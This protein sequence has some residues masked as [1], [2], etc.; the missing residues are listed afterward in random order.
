MS[1]FAYLKS[2]RFWGI[3]LLVV[4][5]LNVGSAFAYVLSDRY[6][7]HWKDEADPINTVIAGLASMVLF[8]LCF[9][10]FKVIY[11]PLPKPEPALK[12]PMSQHYLAVLAISGLQFPLAIYLVDRLI[13][14]PFSVVH[15]EHPSM[16][17]LMLIVF[18]GV[19]LA[20]YE[21]TAKLEGKDKGDFS[22]DR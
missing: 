15:H 21:Q 2:K 10:L 1:R 18:L 8:L 12:G 3:Y 20:T 9:P 7:A 4:L 16:M 13:L 17:V 11:G 19:M 22:P 6:I 5:I 14:A